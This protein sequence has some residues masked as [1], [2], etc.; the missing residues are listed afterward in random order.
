MIKVLE[1]VDEIDLPGTFRGFVEQK[2]VSL[3][4]SWNTD[5]LSAPD[6]LDDLNT[7]AYFHISATILKD[8]AIRVFRQTGWKT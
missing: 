8:L 3:L 5:V 7:K 6:N 2:F 1:S 4:D